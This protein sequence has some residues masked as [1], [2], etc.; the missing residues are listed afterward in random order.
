MKH[1][2]VTG[3]NGSI[4]SVYYPQNP[5]FGGVD[6]LGADPDNRPCSMPRLF[7]RGRGKRSREAPC[8]FFYFS[9]SYDGTPIS[10]PNTKVLL[11]KTQLVRQPIRFLT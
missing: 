4:R 1:E 11:E 9:M 2:H 7:C 5:V 6:K 10:V 3:L 8:C